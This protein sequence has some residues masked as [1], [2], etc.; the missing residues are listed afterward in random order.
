M[1]ETADTKRWLE[2]ATYSIGT[3]RDIYKRDGSYN[4]GISYA[5]YTTLHHHPG[6]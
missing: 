2:Q 3:F 6:R 5:H 1:G 4:E